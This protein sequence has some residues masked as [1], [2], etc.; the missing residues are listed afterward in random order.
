MHRQASGS[1]VVLRA[2]CGCSA[3][4]LSPERIA[5]KIEIRPRA[6]VVTPAPLFLQLELRAA[7]AVCNRNDVDVVLLRAEWTA[8]LAGKSVGAG[9][10]V[11]PRTLPAGRCVDVPV[12]GALD[13]SQLGGAAV[14]AVLQGRS[15][16]PALLVDV[17]AAVYGLSLRRT[18]KLSPEAFLAAEVLPPTEK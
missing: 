17:T 6:M 8:Q 4:E 5:A 18:L 12:V 1:W 14:E 10:V 11:G 7:V 16:I 15:P 3:A 13:V 9:T 2:M